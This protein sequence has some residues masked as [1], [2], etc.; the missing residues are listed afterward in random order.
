M[1]CKVIGN[2]SGIQAPI[3]SFIEQHIDEPHN[4]STREQ[5][6]LADLL[7]E[8]N[9]ISLSYLQSF[10]V[11]DDNGTVTTSY[12]KS[13]YGQGDEDA[14]G[15]AG[16]ITSINSEDG[17]TISINP[18]LG[19]VSIPNA[20]DTIWINASGISAGPGISISDSSPNKV[21]SA[22]L[23]T[24]GFATYSSLHASGY[25]RNTDFIQ[26]GFITKGEVAASGFATRSEL[27]TSGYLQAT[28]RLY[29]VDARAASG[30]I[31]P[32]SSGKWDLGSIANNWDDLH[33]E[34]IIA[35][36][37]IT[38]SGIPI[39]QKVNDLGGPHVTLKAGAGVESIA[40]VDHDIYINVSGSAA[41]LT[42]V[43][44]QTGPGI[45]LLAG[46][47]MYISSPASNIIAID[48]SGATHGEVTVN[49]PY[50]SVNPTA[51][52]G[53]QF[54]VF[55]GETVILEAYIFS[56]T[57]NQATGVGLG[58]TGPAVNTL[59][60]VAE[61]PT[62]ATAFIITQGT[63]YTAITGATSLVTVN[64]SHLYCFASGFTAAGLFGPSWRTE[65]NGGTG[66]VI[67]GSWARIQRLD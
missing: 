54:P 19:I 50:N 2:F 15:E 9:R 13:Y 48:S 62:S 47:G 24:S 40:T 45:T 10:I 55:I 33:I 53:L 28:D 26:S 64:C 23:T 25:I 38:I 18:G 34:R 21:I 29:P 37:G 36:S 3:V 6:Y 39:I 30:H 27:T 44:S 49:Q 31:I 7:C 59:Q 17:P 35:Q 52:S 51:I 32:D 14:P 60:W 20:S 56:T 63:T 12:D 22:D 5:R 16:G 46:S 8:K 41:G 61:I 57:N 66:T 43:N 11:I 4:L 58:M 42:S 67:K 1:L 65:T